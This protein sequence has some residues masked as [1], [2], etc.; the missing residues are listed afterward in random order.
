MAVELDRLG[1]AVDGA[2]GPDIPQANGFSVVSLAVARVGA[3]FRSVV[4]RVGVA[5]GLTDARR[6]VDLQPVFFRSGAADASPTGN[7]W[8]RR[9]ASSRSVWGKLGVIFNAL[10][11]ATVT[12]ATHKTG[13][14]D[15]T[16]FHAIRATRNGAGVEVFMVD[17]DLAWCGG[18]GQSA[19]AARTH[20]SCCPTEGPATR[21]SRT[22]SGTCSVSAILQAGQTPGRSWTRAAR[23]A[24]GTRRG[25]RAPTTTASPGLLR[26]PPHTSRRIHDGTRRQQLRLSRARTPRALRAGAARSRRSQGR[27]ASPVH[28]SERRSRRAARSPSPRT[29]GVRSM[30]RGVAEDGWIRSAFV[31]EHGGPDPERAD[32]NR[33]ERDSR[34]QPAP[35]SEFPAGVRAQA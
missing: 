25:T 28:C 31:V 2:R 19:A 5:L 18:G 30:V 24:P 11:S 23:T 8:A 1:G 34:S 4:G 9:L 14:A 27:C 35:Q 15:A 29:R 3:F 10:G 13:G 33:A 16:E 32:G 17:N 21:C 7:S 26:E 22:S 6:S 20:R 12:D